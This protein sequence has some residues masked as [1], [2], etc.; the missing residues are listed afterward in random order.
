MKRIVMPALVLLNLALPP[1]AGDTPAYLS[2]D[3]LWSA[4]RLCPFP[5]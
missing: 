5:D 1:G 4:N 3:T 2:S